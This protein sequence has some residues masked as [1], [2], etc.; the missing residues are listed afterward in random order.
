MNGARVY[1]FRSEIDSSSTP[2]TRHDMDSYHIPLSP[3]PFGESTLLNVLSALGVV[4]ADP[5]S[6]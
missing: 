6:K 5:N 1:S 4:T 3:T 2:G